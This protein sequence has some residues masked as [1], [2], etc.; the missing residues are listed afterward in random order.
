MVSI[1]ARFFPQSPIKMGKGGIKS[2][3]S[4]SSGGDP[5]AIWRPGGNNMVDAGKA[6]NAYNGLVFACVNAIAREVA[7]MQ[8]KLYQISEDGSV[9]EIVESEL[10]DLLDGVNDR[11]TGPEFKYTIGTHLELTG[12]AYILMVGVTNDT[13]KP[14]S[15]VLLDP[16]RVRIVY[17]KTIFPW[18]VKGYQF[19]IENRIYNYQA[20]EIV[21][22]KYPNP[23]D[24]FVGIGA[25]Q[26]IAPWIDGDNDAMELNRQFF[27]NGTKLGIVMESEMTDEAMI[28]RLR[29][30]WD[31]THGGIENASKPLILPKGVTLANSSNSNQQKDMDM[32]N[33]MDQMQQRILMG[34]GVSRT[35]L[36]T[37]ESDTNRATAETADYIFSHRVVKPKMQ[38]IISYL[39]EFLVPRFGEKIY[40]GFLDPTPEDKS[41]RIQEMQAVMASTQVLTLNETREKFEGLGPVDGGDVIYAPFGMV[42]IGSPVEDEHTGPTNAED[43]PVTPQ[44]KPT[45]G[46]KAKIGFVKTRFAKNAERRRK[47]SKDFAEKVTSKLSLIS[48]K[49]TIDLNDEEYMIVWQKFVDRVDTAS[50]ALKQEIQKFNKKQSEVVIKNI[51]DKFGNKGLKT[52]SEIKESDLFD[53]E[54]WVKFMVDLVGPILNDLAKK[55][56]EEAAAG[57][58]KPGY[59]ILED[60]GVADSLDKSI[61]LLSQ[62]YNDT[63]LDLLKKQMTEGLEAGESLDKLT[64]RVQSIYEFSD[65]NRAEMV[66]HTETFRI[67]NYAT[68]E[69]WKETGVTEIKFY[70]AKDSSVCEFC[71]EMD[72]KVISIQ[73]NFFDK[74]DSLTVDGKTLNFDYSDVEAPPIHPRCRCYERPETFAPIE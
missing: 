63:T 1:P 12:N 74:G 7:Q 59:N 31:N 45:K 25:V 21:H 41:F 13:D 52:K 70:T 6:L 65:R 22:L 68:K 18:I 49:K 48:L 72:G 32:A 60:A 16:S 19:T 36:G 46:E 64:D 42:P 50:H 44:N 14:N 23:A 20:Y 55:E 35:I 56:G 27:I 67:A 38:Q 61:K 24:P 29:I 34:F 53:Q 26:A 73:D 58:G 54:E 51:S 33:F 40:L 3:S 9:E 37:A 8:F 4:S 17:D 66:A 62:S 39:N 30:T 57:F 71:A 28:D 2:F 10:L 47:I 5:F 15:L 43:K 11:Q 69:G